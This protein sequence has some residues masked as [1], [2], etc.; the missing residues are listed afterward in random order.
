MKTLIALLVVFTFNVEPY[1]GKILRVIDGDTFVLQTEEGNLKIR[2]GGIDAPEKDQD[3]GLE[4]GE[5][6]NRYINKNVKVIPSG[7]DRYGRTIGTLYFDGININLLEVREGYAWH[8]KK[9]SNDQKMANAEELAKK[10]KKGLWR[11]LNVIPPWEW[12][13]HHLA[14]QLLIYSN[15]Y[16]TGL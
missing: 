2:M 12:R 5:F 1:V 8:Y 15:N 9:Y 6:L 7:V 16:Y 10:E 11:S 4:A 13:K 3:F 14:K